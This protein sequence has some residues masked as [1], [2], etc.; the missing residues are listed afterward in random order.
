MGD[1]RVYGRVAESVEVGIA[2]YLL[3]LG[4]IKDIGL[5]IGNR[6]PDTLSLF[7]GKIIQVHHSLTSLSIILHGLPFLGFLRLSV[8][9][10]SIDE[11][12][13]LS[14]IVRNAVDLDR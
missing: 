11:T 10:E 2:V 6:V 9:R 7:L 3:A 5:H 13:Q 14:H 1:S 12:C 8:R 4:V